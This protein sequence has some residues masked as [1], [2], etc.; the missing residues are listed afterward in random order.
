MNYTYQ[1][2]RYEAKKKKKKNQLSVIDSPSLFYA[3]ISTKLALSGV[4]NAY[5]RAK[6]SLHEIYRRM[7]QIIHLHVCNMFWNV[8]LLFTARQRRVTS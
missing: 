6:G 8:S 7:E 3:G 5:Y 1:N 2:N 4:L